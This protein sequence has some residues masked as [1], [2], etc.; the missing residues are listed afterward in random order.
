MNGVISIVILKLI[1]EHTE[2]RSFSDKTLWV[3]CIDQD[4]KKRHIKVI[5]IGS[6]VKE[7]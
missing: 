2:C 1:L 4:K 6:I 5:V 7:L 3:Y